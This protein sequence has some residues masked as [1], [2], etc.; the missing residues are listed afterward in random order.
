MVNRMS[1]QMELLCLAILFCIPAASCVS[2]HHTP[3]LLEMDTEFTKCHS[4]AK[5]INNTAHSGSN[6]SGCR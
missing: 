4:S 2:E 6:Y 1:P 5:V 3:P